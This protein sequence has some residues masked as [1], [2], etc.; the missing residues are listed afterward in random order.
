MARDDCEECK[1]ALLGG[2]SRNWAAFAFEREGTEGF[3]PKHGCLAMQRF[4]KMRGL[5]DNWLQT[6]HKEGTWRV[7]S[8]TLDSPYGLVLDTGRRAKLLDSS[9][10]RL[11]STEEQ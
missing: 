10:K 7:S 2:R 4:R 5:S 8:Q 9:F 3:Q 6:G 1:S 11:M